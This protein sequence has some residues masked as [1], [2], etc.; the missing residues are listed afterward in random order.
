MI[1]EFDES[2]SLQRILA[3]GAGLCGVLGRD[4]DAQGNRL[5]ALPDTETQLVA[6]LAAPLLVTDYYRFARWVGSRLRHA[7]NPR[8]DG[9]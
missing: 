6:T 1:L 2:L 3:H 9:G 8:P 7:C 4:R 5:A